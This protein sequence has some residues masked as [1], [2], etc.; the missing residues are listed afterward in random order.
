[1]K[2]TINDRSVPRPDA[3][4]FSITDRK[5]VFQQNWLEADVHHSEASRP[6]ADFSDCE[7]SDLRSMVTVQD[8][9]AGILNGIDSLIVR[10][11][12]SYQ[13]CGA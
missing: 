5:E 4:D 11:T 12:L 6:K 10:P 9:R 1:M 8:L 3:Y 7:I 13:P 2:L